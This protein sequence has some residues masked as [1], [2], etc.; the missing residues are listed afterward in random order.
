MMIFMNGE[1]HEKEKIIE[2]EEELLKKLMKKENVRSR[3]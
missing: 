1:Y 2:K 3:C